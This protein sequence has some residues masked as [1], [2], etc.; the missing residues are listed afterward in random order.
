MQQDCRLA[1]AVQWG[2]EVQ[3]WLPL[4]YSERWVM[5]VSFTVC[6]VG[7]PY[8]CNLVECPGL[9]GSLNSTYKSKWA[10]VGRSLDRAGWVSTVTLISF[11]NCMKTTS[12]INERLECVCCILNT[13]QGYVCHIHACM[14]H[15][16]SR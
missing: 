11:K 9:A 6:A 16:E 1:T 10:A 7:F 5:M 14:V 4:R 15:I 8:A 12:V 3:K 2:A 13:L